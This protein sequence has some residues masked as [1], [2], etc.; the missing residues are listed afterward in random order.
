MPDI[1]PLRS[2]F[3]GC[4]LGGAVGDAL[5][6]PVEFDTHARI[7]ARYGHNGPSELGR[8]YGVDGAITD[9]TQMTLWTAEGLL[10][11]AHRWETRGIAHLPSMVHRAYV[12]WLL[13]QDEPFPFGEGGITRDSVADGWLWRHQALHAERA[14][15]ATCLSALASGVMGTME[16]PVNDSKGCGGV[17]RAAPAGLMFPPGRAFEV[18]C[19][20]AA[21]THGHPT[22]YVAS[23]ALAETVAQLM[24]GA[25]V[26]EALSAAEAA[27]RAA[28][29]GAET[30]DALV[31]AERL[32]GSSDTDAAAVQA[33]AVVTPGRGAGWVAEEALAVAALCARRYPEDAERAVRM[34]VTHTGDSD[35]TGSICGQI[36]GAALG[37]EAIPARWVEAVELREVVIQIADDLWAR[38]AGEHGWEAR[39]PPG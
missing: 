35:S 15:G 6:A 20:T 39:Y 19:E 9:D 22:G 13:T 33:L 16:D 25:T 34:A 36:L 26:A 21:I 2:Q 10:R 14:P 4:L 17:M 3:R 23:G 37:D 31:A 30:A 29:G 5:G 12:R 8:A 11:G 27:A 38:A 24:G 18:G 1:L 32:A 28:E 7:V